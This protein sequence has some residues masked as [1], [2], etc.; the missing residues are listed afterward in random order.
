[1][2]TAIVAMWLGGCSGSLGMPNTGSGGNGGGGGLGTGGSSDGSTLKTYTLHWSA[3][4]EGVSIPVGGCI[5][6]N[7]APQMLP[8]STVS[9]MLQ[10]GGSE[11]FIDTYEVGVVPSGNDCHFLQG[12]AG[13]YVDT[14]LSGSGDA[15]GSVP[16]GTYDLDVR[17]LATTNIG[18]SAG[19]DASASGGVC[20]L[21]TVY[22]SATY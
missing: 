18:P 5:I 11:Y 20:M 16:A 12:D 8:A 15:S 13:A 9:V 10:D 2:R 19:Y 14:V 1:M 4:S 3:S 7:A 17:C 22:W 6:V 21:S